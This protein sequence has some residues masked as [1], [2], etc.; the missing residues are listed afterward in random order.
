[1]HPA[2]ATVEAPA[3]ARATSAA[4]LVAAVEPVAVEKMEATG[5]EVEVVACREDQG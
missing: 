4:E 5:E 2:E 3:V 1:L